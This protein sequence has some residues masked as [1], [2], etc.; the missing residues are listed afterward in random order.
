[1]LFRSDSN[2]DFLIPGLVYAPASFTRDLVLPPSLYCVKSV[3]SRRGFFTPLGILDGLMSPI[4]REA[5]MSAVRLA[6]FVHA[7]W[8]RTGH[9]NHLAFG[10]AFGGNAV[11]AG[12]SSFD[13]THFGFG[14]TVA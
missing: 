3:S 11:F 12:S 2:S 8:F 6:T 1:M 5:I 9:G 4:P 7:Q 13:R 14:D 10:F